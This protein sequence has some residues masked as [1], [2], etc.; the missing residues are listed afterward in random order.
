MK[1]L[2]LIMYLLMTHFL[3]AEQIPHL[4]L[5]FDIN[6]TLIASDK[7]ENKSIE[8]VINELLSK[9]YSACWDEALQE[10][11]T[12]EAYV[13][14]IILPGDEHNVKL[15]EERLDYLIHFIDYLRE[16]HHPYYGKVLEEFTLVVDILK[17]VQGNVFPSFYRLIFELNQSGIPYTLFLRSFGKEVFEVTNEINSE[18]KE[19][20]K[21]NG[22]F[23][24]GILYLDGKEALSDS[25]IIYDFF[26]AKE[27]AAIHDDWG[28][29][30]E[31]EME[32]IYGKPVYIDQED[33]SVLTL[34][35]DDNIKT[36]PS[37]KNIISPIDPKTGESISIAKLIQFKQLIP[38]NT[39]EAILN[40]FY[41]LERVQ[42]AIKIHQNNHQIRFELSSE[43]MREDDHL[44]IN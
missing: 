8:D 21:I 5:H 22:M 27:N 23:R 4:L 12:F 44:A 25:H 24:K 31:G 42:E 35:F 43:V 20:F 7:T 36:D 1:S 29:W 26:S 41:Y 13:K 39:L 10:P 37:E 17:K 3:E 19:L 34:F 28:Y 16:H 32:A 2:L 6:K 9:K 14:T 40:E 38:V 11:L 30:M 33:S 15:K 18:F